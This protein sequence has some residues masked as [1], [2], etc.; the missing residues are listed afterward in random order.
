MRGGRTASLAVVATALLGAGLLVPGPAV[1]V[2]DPTA[3][4]TTVA[5]PP[6][7]S[8]VD[9]APVVAVIALVT[10]L[11]APIAGLIVRTSTVDGAVGHDEAPAQE[12]FTL[13]GDVFFETNSAVLTPRA[14]AELATVAQALLDTAPAAV[15]VVGHT[16]SVADDAHNQQL[17]VERATAVQQFLQGQVPSVQ[18]SVE[19]RGESQP[20]AAEE[21]SPEQIAQAQA[22][23][24]RVEV[25]ATHSATS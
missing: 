4:P 1:A 7:T 3:E 21:G 19:G 15:Q 11:V 14:L 22:L 23:N 20:V 18:I 9:I 25:T 13:S 16:D 8:S 12:Q 6:A 2:D 24:R 5:V 17:S 10:P